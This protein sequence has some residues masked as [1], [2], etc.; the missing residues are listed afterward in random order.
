ML[1]L[2][3]MGARTLIID[4]SYTLMRMENGV[5]KPFYHEWS[6]DISSVEWGGE[7][8]QIISEPVLSAG[9]YRFVKVLGVQGTTAKKTLQVDFSWDG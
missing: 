3:N 2:L 9:N 7:F 6:G 8:K 1:I 4:D 5:Y